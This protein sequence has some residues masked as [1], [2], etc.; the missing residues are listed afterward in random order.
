MSNYPRLP[1]YTLTTSMTSEEIYRE[2]RQ[3]SDT[4][5]FELDIRDKQVESTPSFNVR[6]VTTVTNIGRPQ[7]GDVAFASN[8]SKF[9]GYIEGTGWVDFN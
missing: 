1:N 3:Y 5:S 9:R 7:N 6:T 2:I 4:L 8:S